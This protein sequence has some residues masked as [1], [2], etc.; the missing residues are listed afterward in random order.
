MPAILDE[1]FRA[2]GANDQPA[3]P[4]RLMSANLVRQPKRLH[5]QEFS[6][7]GPLDDHSLKSAYVAQAK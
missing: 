5:P 4:L 1:E 6:G 3:V 2:A 7:A